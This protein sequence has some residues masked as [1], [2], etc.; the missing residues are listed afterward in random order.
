MAESEAT[1]PST[2][3]TAAEGDFRDSAAAG[4]AFGEG[5]KLEDAGDRVG[6]VEKY[7]AA[8]AADPDDAN[9]SFRLAY[10]LDLLGEEDEAIHLYEECVRTPQ[11]PL[12]ALINL[13][14]LYEDRGKLPQAERCVRQVLATDPNHARARLFIKDILASREMVIDDDQEKRDDRH[15]ALLDVPVTDFEMDYRTRNSLRKMDIKTLG[16]LLRVSEAELR[17]YKNFGEASI[18]EIKS[19]LAQ[20]GLRLGQDLERAQEKAREER[21]SEVEAESGEGNLMER[22]VGELD[23]SVRARKA[24]ALLSVDSLGD[25]VMMTEAEL[26]GV[27]NFGA[28]T[29][30]EIKEKLVAAG[31]SLRTLEA[32]E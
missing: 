29:L 14:V 30:D 18:D 16:D 27:K 22:S 25:L 5:Q 31:L 28:T 9:I 21:L 3:E 6:A 15:A 26:M 11:A 2:D 8:Y 4:K 12:H 13:A 20:K 1:T 10:N 7:E 32:P 23:L 19:M 17:S 24:L